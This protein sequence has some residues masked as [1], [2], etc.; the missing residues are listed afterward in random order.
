M[1][2]WLVN[3][4]A[5]QKCG[6]FLKPIIMRRKIIL[7]IIF[8]AVTIGVSSGLIY[9]NLTNQC[10]KWDLGLANTKFDNSS[11]DCKIKTPKK[12]K[13]SQTDKKLIKN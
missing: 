13:K 6:A 2:V 12:K 4:K 3:E 10:K 9:V 5:L 8:L 1:C 11:F 7:T